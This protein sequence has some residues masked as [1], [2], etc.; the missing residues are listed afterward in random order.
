MR[1]VDRPVLEYSGALEMYSDYLENGIDS[2]V[3]SLLSDES[4]MIKIYKN[5]DAALSDFVKSELV[6]FNML[7]MATTIVEA[8]IY[9]NPEIRTVKDFLETFE[10][11]DDVELYNYIAGIIAET[12]CGGE[13]FDKVKKSVKKMQTYI[14]E[15]VDVKDADYDKLTNIMEYTQE[16]RLRLRLLFTSFYEAY[17]NNE[18]IVLKNAEKI[19]N[20]YEKKYNKDDDKTLEIILNEH[21]QWNMAAELVKR[22]KIDIY[23]SYMKCVTNQYKIYNENDEFICIGFRNSEYLMLKQKKRDIPLFC[24]LLNDESRRKM[25]MLMSEREYYLQELANELSVKPP[26]VNHHIQLFEELGIIT[27]RGVD[28]SLRVYYQINKEALESYIDGLKE[29]LLRS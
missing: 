28:D 10:N 3:Y 9:D 17:S 24:K 7:R 4:D 19:K 13:G 16:T 15:R 1:F 5:I 22:K 21:N 27:R 8:F 14:K 29:M 11:A 6:Y 18:I 12:I 26:T 20:D 23:I 2:Q 25:I